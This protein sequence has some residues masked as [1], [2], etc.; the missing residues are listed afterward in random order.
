M[1]THTQSWEYSHSDLQKQ[2]LIATQSDLQD[3]WSRNP[4]CEKDELKATM[5]V[6]VANEGGYLSDAY[7]R[8][9]EKEKKNERKKP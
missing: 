3:G 9:K 1:D 8:R 4:E 2:G 5:T 6:G 7:W